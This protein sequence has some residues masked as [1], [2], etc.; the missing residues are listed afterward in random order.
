MIF[1][2]RQ[3]VEI[4]GEQHVGWSRMDPIFGETIGVMDSEF[5]GEAEVAALAAS[6]NALHRRLP[7]GYLAV[8]DGAAEGWDK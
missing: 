5:H 4:D 3:A 7:I 2:P 1:V 8:G 6:L